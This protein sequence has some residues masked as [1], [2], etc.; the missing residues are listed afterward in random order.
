MDFSTWTFYD[1]TVVGGLLLNAIFT[2]I[3]KF[4]DLRHI[5]KDL[6]TIKK[7]IADIKRTQVNHGERISHIEGKLDG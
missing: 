1:W 3:N 6:D 5:S 4:N 7:G 2:L